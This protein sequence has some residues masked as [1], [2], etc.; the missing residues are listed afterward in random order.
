M[1]QQRLMNKDVDEGRIFAAVAY[2]W[3][4]CLV[5]LMLKRSNSFAVFHGKQ[6]LVLFIGEVAIS[7]IG[8]IP[9]I[10]W[11]VFFLGSLVFGC[12]AL[13]GTIQALLGNRW[14]M[15]VVCEIAEKIE[16]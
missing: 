6:G 7:I 15:P 4:L 16:L 5:P 1:S 8:V 14:R 9:V 11:V 3:I 12:A 13:A 2:L 10:G